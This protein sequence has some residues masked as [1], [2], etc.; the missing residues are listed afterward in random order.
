MLIKHKFDMF[1]HYNF[2]SNVIA[3]DPESDGEL[4]EPLDDIIKYVVLLLI[5]MEK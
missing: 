3:D 2:Q 5:C 1:V 4:Y